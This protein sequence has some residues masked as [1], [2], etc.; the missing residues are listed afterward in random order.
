M[1]DR[2]KE[3]PEKKE[4]NEKEHKPEKPEQKEGE[5]GEEGENGEHKH[6]ELAVFD[7]YEQIKIDSFIIVNAQR[8]YGKT[9]WIRWVLSLLWP[10]FAGGGYVF[11]K[12][13]QN[14]FWSQ[15]FPQTRIYNGLAGENMEILRKILLKQK[16]KHEK[17]LLAND[18]SKTPYIIIIL[19]DVIGDQHSVRYNNYLNDVVFAGRH[20]NTMMFVTTQDAKVY[21][22][23]FI[24][25]RI[26]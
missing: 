23:P 2:K 20:Y 7:P 6:I 16:E 25:M 15:H 4:V 19:D 5:K 12:T 26:L 22:Q 18:F 14:R 8:R 13:K 1:G 21:H 17:M 10:F 3:E 24:K 9:I 11:T